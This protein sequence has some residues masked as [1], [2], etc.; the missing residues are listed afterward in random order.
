VIVENLSF[1][2]VGSV[3]VIPYNH[4]NIEWDVNVITDIDWLTTND[5]AAVLAVTG[6]VAIVASFF[7][8]GPIAALLVAAGIIAIIAGGLI[9]ITETVHEVLG[10]GG[11]TQIWQL[12]T[13]PLGLVLIGISA[14]Y[15][16]WTATGRGFVSSTGRAA[17]PYVKRGAVAAGGRIKRAAKSGGNDK[18]AWDEIAALF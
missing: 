1:P 2:V 6:V 13:S 17:A 9:S 16:V 8:G 11:I 10:G 14:G 5:L 12:I 7:I 3:D 4:Y 18:S 15:F